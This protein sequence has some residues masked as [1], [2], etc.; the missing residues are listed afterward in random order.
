M[1]DIQEQQISLAALVCPVE[2]IYF[3]RGAWPTSM[4]S[5]LGHH[6]SLPIQGIRFD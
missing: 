4:R 3:I 5:F 1:S 6:H 2:L